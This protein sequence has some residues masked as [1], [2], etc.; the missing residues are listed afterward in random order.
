MRIDW[1]WLSVA[2]IIASMASCTAISDYAQ[3]KYG[4][5]HCEEPAK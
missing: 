5:P 2:I 1:E 3:A 4:R